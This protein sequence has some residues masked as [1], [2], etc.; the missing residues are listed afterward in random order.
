MSKMAWYQLSMVPV[1]WLPTPLFEI[2][3]FKIQHLYGIKVSKRDRIYCIQHLL[4][5]IES[6]EYTAL[7]NK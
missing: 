6:Q 2:T 4:P 7:K 3:I 5:T 1:V